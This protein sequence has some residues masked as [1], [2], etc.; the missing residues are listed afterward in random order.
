MEETPAY[1]QSTYGDTPEAPAGEPVILP[2][3]SLS[4]YRKGDEETSAARPVATPSI[5]ETIVL[6]THSGFTVS[7]DWDGGSILPGE[8]LSRHRRP[9]ARPESR[10]SE[11]SAEHRVDTRADLRHTPEPV[12]PVPVAPVQA[13][14][15]ETAPAEYEPTEASA[16]YRV[17]PVVQ[18]EFRQSA[19]VLEPEATPQAA[20]ETPAYE[21]P[22]QN[23]TPP[24]L[25][26]RT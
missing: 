12:A 19:P 3:E 8:T 1:G 21:A 16:S 13:A 23:A 24:P 17:D 7:S 4:K 25:R 14:P 26:A 15:V 2:G 9:E 10:R 20:P 5:A 22:E 18:S 6:P 11:P